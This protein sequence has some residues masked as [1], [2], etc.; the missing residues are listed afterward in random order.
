M[1]PE[2]RGRE[3]VVPDILL[4]GARDGYAALRWRVPTGSRAGHPD[5]GPADA[6]AATCD[7]E[8]LLAAQDQRASG[9]ERQG[10][11]L[12]VGILA[13][14]VAVPGATETTFSLLYAVNTLGAV[15]GSALTGFVFVHFFGMRQTLWIAAL[16]NFLVALNAGLS[17][18]KES[19][20]PR[21][22]RK[23]SPPLTLTA[24]GQGV[25]QWVAIA[26][27][28][29][30]GPASMALEVTWT[31]VLGILTSNSAYGFALVLTVLLLGLGL[32]AM[33]QSCWSKRPGDSWRR[34]AVCQWLLAGVS[35]LSLPFFRT[36]PG[37]LARCC[38]GSS[39]TADSHRDLSA[40]KA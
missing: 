1:R 21:S 28:A 6:R 20:G 12:Q 7:R 33:L 17:S 29:T 38:D 4:P 27:A 30:T 13:F 31:R 2:V 23:E 40:F 24:C 18:R 16:L 11:D 34:L 39:V 8:T 37:W 26:C 35:L 5:G 36:T 9:T 25:W 14:P 32:G 10:A 3:P 19:R 22:W 15:T